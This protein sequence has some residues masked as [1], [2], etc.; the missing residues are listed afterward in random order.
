LLLTTHDMGD[1]ERLCDRV[2]VVDRG[3]LAFDAQETTAATLLAEVSRRCEVRDLSIEEPDTEDVV[4][5]IYQE[6]R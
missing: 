3:R 2:L 1:I 5:R 4:R 6:S